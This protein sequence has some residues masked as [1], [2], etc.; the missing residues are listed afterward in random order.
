[1][2]KIHWTWNLLPTL[3]HQ[4]TEIL[5]ALCGAKSEGTDSC[6]LLGFLLPYVS[7]N[8]NNNVRRKQHGQL[9]FGFVHYPP[10]WA[11]TGN[12]PLCSVMIIIIFL[13]RQKSVGTDSCCRLLCK[14]NRGWTSNQLIAV[15]CLMA[16]GTFIVLKYGE[17][18][19]LK[20]SQKMFG[21]LCTEKQANLS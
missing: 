11:P 14:E 20:K 9:L 13:R 8:K 5:C 2:H 1:M 21:R 3:S 16:S 10:F 12:T 17:G 15:S 18:V 6:N 7:N 19:G 4:H